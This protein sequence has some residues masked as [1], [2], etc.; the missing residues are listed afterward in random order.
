MKII[1][2]SVCGP[3]RR[4]TEFHQETIGTVGYLIIKECPTICGGLSLSISVCG[5]IRL[6]IHFNSETIGTV[7][8]QIIQAI[9]VS[10]WWSHSYCFSVWIH[11]V[12]TEL[13]LETNGIVEHLSIKR[14]LSICGSLILSLSVCGYCRLWTEFNQETIG[15]AEHQILQAISVRL[16]WFESFSFSVWIHLPVS[17]IPNVIINLS[18]NPGAAPGI[19]YEGALE[20]SFTKNCKNCM[21]WRTLSYIDVMPLGSAT[22]IYVI[23]YS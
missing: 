16:W 10:M 19:P 5:C 22:E 21:K 6:W 11:W 18:L 1:F 3:I 13:N 20:Y 23:F 2:A 4:G 14:F 15:T 17:F 12:W 9:L 8:H 7:E